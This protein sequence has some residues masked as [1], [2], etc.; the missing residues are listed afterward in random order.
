MHKVEG[1]GGML[2]PIEPQSPKGL[3]GTF[4]GRIAKVFSK[5]QS[6]PSQ[7]ISIGNVASKALDQKT[8][9]L[10]GISSSGHSLL[11]MPSR[12][13]SA[14]Y[15]R[16]EDGIT[17][18][19][20]RVGIL[21]DI[22]GQSVHPIGNGANGMV[23]LLTI[24]DPQTSLPRMVVLKHLQ[25]CLFDTTQSSWEEWDT[26][27]EK[28]ADLFHEAQISK[29]LN[30]HPNC[31]HMLDAHVIP[32][33]PGHV[34]YTIQ[35]PISGGSLQDRLD[36]DE[37][38][39]VPLETKIKWA[40]Q[41]TSAVSF[42]NSLHIA[43]RDLKSDNIM[44]TTHGLDADVKLIDFGCAA[45]IGV[46]GVLDGN[47]RAQPPELEVKHGMCTVPESYDSWGLGWTLC[48]ML[49]DK[50]SMRQLGESLGRDEIP[51]AQ[52]IRNLF[53]SDDIRY[54]HI[55]EC[56]SGLLNPDPK[57]RLTTHQAKEMLTEY[58]P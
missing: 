31:G 15:W 55:A 21:L 34:D 4:F 6:T 52:Q 47:R 7:Q 11:E 38:A 12:F 58:F 26:A 23:K 49:A 45:E 10:G 18:R 30:A 5:G 28:T 43:H 35:E 44:L 32:G 19:E 8:D 56:V 16:P 24:T 9:T 51:T 33:H 2:P 57:I 36:S 41:L 37:L 25:P 42:M 48:D 39:T 22:Q 40:K 53:P 27:K 13:G 50:E 1:Q 29:K 17:T 54:D 46:R 14:P 20:N 3:L